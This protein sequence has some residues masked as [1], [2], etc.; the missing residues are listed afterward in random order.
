M[1][2]GLHKPARIVSLLPSATEI[3]CALGLGDR[4]VGRSHECDYP[5][6]IQR[7][8][9]CTSAT[10]DSA[11]P[12]GEIDRQ[13]KT[14]RQQSRP[15]YQ[16]DLAKLRELRPDLILTQAQC[17]VCAVD[18]PAVE[19]AVSQWT[20]SR[21]QILSLSPR[22]IAEVWDEI[23][24]VSAALGEEQKGREV[25]R[26]LKNRCV[27][28]IEKTCAVKHRPSV[29]CLEW[30]DPL[31]AAG[32]W[33]PELV[34]LAG[35]GNLFGEPGKPSPMLNWETFAERDPEVIV[36][37]PCGFDITRTLRELPA[38][39]RQAGW[40]RLRA[41]KKHRVFVTDG[42]AYFNRPGP[43]LV[44]SLEILAELFHPKRFPA[45]HHGT[46]WEQI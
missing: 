42:N 23:R 12:S 43:R 17:E 2:G 19:Q 10:L 37:M 20:G 6:E 5:P 39:A 18:L 4:L 3:V 8:P 32:N 27:D 13:V 46:G 9:V 35:G 38:L 33:V 24:R 7:L 30:I 45:Q 16:I 14:L 29:A 25:L 40:A 28:V 26:A 44:E 15:L 11:A 36:I 31:M 21:P 22:R 34:D 1:S 41:V